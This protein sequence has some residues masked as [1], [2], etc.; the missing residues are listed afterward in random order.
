MS[1][2]NKKYIY[3]AFLSLK[4]KMKLFY[5]QQ[6]KQDTILFIREFDG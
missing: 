4:N 6:S 2:W 5:T 1:P 3:L